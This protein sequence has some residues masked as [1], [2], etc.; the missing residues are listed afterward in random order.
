MQPPFAQQPVLI[1]VL[2]VT[3]LIWRV[4]EAALDIRSYGRLRA[5]VQRQDNGSR[6]LLACLIV[7]GAGLGTVIA[8]QVSATA[9]P[10]GRIVF[11]W[12]G[13]LLMYAGI[14]LRLYAVRVLGA[15]FTTSLATAPG[16]PVIETGPYRLIRHPSYT[17]ILLTLLGF[18]LCLANW[19]GLLVL[20]AGALLGFWYRIR[21]EERVL[22]K[23][24]GQPYHDYMRRTKRLIPFVL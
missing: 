13:I 16:Q 7:L 20:M 22:Q 9:I 24:L 14:V 19:L 10:F 3:F 6:L 11:F 15:Y 18:G 4:I 21:V 8:F 2:V 12:L 23:Q 5:G 17:G 1:Y